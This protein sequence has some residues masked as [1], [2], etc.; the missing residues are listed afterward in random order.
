M[1]RDV[2]HRVARVPPRSRSG[3]LIGRSSSPCLDAPSG[4]SYTISHHTTLPRRPA[5]FV[6]GCDVGTQST[7]A[8][9][10]DDGGAIIGRGARSTAV[11]HPRPGW[12]EQDPATW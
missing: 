5:I 9:L 8:I 6:I 12:S 2:D 3:R 11:T 1:A 4:T 7:K 10:L